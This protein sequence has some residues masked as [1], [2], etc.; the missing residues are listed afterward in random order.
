M[1]KRILCFGDSLTWGF[2]P[3]DCSRYDDDVRW[4]G[5]LQKLFG[6]DYKIIEEGQ[7]GRTIAMDDPVE[8]EKNGLTYLIPCLDSQC[9]LDG[10]VILLGTND[11]KER[12][13]LTAEG[14]ADEMDIFLNKVSMF[15]EAVLGGKLK[16]I[17]VSPPHIPND[18]RASCFGESFGYENGQKKSKELGGFYEKLAKKYNTLFLDASK[19]VTVSDTDCLHLEADQQILLAKAVYE[20]YND[21]VVQ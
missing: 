9:P 14:I 7:N 6:E 5:E 19:Y 1:K 17:L 16:V 12:F 15:N 18:M 21:I 4:T 8:G 20:C 2:N 13:G 10:M 3:H 11:L